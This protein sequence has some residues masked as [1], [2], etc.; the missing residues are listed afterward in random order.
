[1]DIIEMAKMYLASNTTK[2]GADVLIRKLIDEVE[3]WRTLHEAERQ[4][5]RLVSPSKAEES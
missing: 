2:T 5:H 3:L 1:M 4:A